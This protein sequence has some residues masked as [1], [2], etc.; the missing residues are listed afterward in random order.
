VPPPDAPQAPAPAILSGPGAFF[1]SVVTG[2]ADQVRVTVKPAAAAAIAS[3]FTFPLALTIAVLL[4]VAVQSRLDSRDPK[5]R[6][7]PSTAGETYVAFEE[8][9][10]L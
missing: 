10:N 7:A 8:E 4:Y 6:L 5:F 1:A 9:D 2:V 3:T